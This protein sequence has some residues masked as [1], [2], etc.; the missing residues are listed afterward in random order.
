MPSDQPATLSDSLQRLGVELDQPTQERIEHF[1]RLLWEWNEKLNLTRHTDYDTFAKRDIVDCL[2]LSRWL[3]QGESVLDVGSGGGVPGVLLAILRPDLDMTLTESMQK[4]AKALASMVDQLQLPLAIHACR[5]E[6]ILEDFRYDV[7][8]ARGRSVVE[9][10]PVVSA[11]LG[12]HWPDSADQR[13]ALGGGTP[14]GAGKGAAAIDRV[15]ANRVV[16]D[17]RHGFRERHSPALAQRPRGPLTREAS[18][19]GAAKQLPATNGPP[20]NRG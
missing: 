5:A 1:C 3:E 14:R 4:K 11:P 12:I 10:L 17:G 9:D 19:G 13:P 15:A 7:L 6:S 2:Q 20:Y 16:P 18:W 8:V